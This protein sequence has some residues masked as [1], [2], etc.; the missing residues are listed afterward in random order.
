MKYAFYDCN[1]IPKEIVIVIVQLPTLSTST[2]K[3]SAMAAVEEGGG[4]ASYRELPRD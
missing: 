2:V 4:I 3:L 1:A